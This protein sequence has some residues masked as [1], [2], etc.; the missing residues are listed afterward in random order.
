MAQRKVTSSVKSARR[1]LPIRFLARLG[2][3][4]NGLLHAIIGVVAITIA[5]RG[6]G[7]KADQSGALAQLAETPGGG[8]LLWVVTIGLAALGTWLIVG[9][10]LDNNGSRAARRRHRLIEGAKGLAYLFVAATA[11]IFALGGST[12][13]SKDA[14]SITA[15]LLAAP[16]GV[17]LVVVLA[18][19]VC[20]IGGYFIRKGVRREFRSDIR[21][22]RGSAGRVIV[23]LG[24][25]GYVAKGVALFVLGVLLG[26]AALTSDSAKSSGLDGALTT[27]ATLPYGKVIL[28]VIGFGFIAYGVYCVV[29]SRVAKL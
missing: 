19:L 11:L 17:V 27:L 23:A 16:G 22:P 9:A 21:V 12:N 2:F 18:I 4:V 5:V 28:V 8:L 26:I 6:G 24:V 20:V 1:S 10:F 15:T 7:A 14:R 3:A 13:S 29:R 25:F